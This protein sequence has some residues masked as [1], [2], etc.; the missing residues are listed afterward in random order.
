MRW[1]S[2]AALGLFVVT[3][4]AAP[5]PLGSNRDWSISPVALALGATLL[6]QAIGALRTPDHVMHLGSLAPAATGFVAVTI[7]ALLQNSPLS[8]FAADDKMLAQAYA[9]MGTTFHPQ[10]AIRPDAVIPGIIRWWSYAAAFWLS[11]QFARDLRQAR[12]ILITFIAAACA[13]TLYGL[14]AEA[15]AHFPVN[16]AALFPKIGEGFSGTFVNKNN[17]ATYAGVGMLTALA[18][19]KRYLPSSRERDL[20][21][22]LKA[23][24]LIGSMSGTPALYA[25]AIVLLFAGVMLSISRGG[26]FSLF[27]GLIAA[28]LL[29]RRRSLLVVVIMVIAGLAL[30]GA[31]VGEQIISRFVSMAIYGGDSRGDLYRLTIEGISLRPWTGW[32]LGSFLSVYSL[33]QPLHL[34]HLDFDKAHDTYLELLLDLGI[35]FGVL[36]LAIVPSILVRC[37]IGLRARARDQEIAGLAISSSILVGVHA[38]F[39][40]SLQIPAMGL[41]YAAI[42]GVGWA[43]SWSSREVA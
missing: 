20:P 22:R 39:D 9:T 32:G 12:F 40:F 33:L 2:L 38:L 8:A 4:F 34:G 27:C 7:W 16:G 36:M 29:G 21:F 15:S 19:L 11:A 3:L 37:V 31:T 14:L 24:R 10:I 28:W 25:A 41:T 6:I 17:Y 26:I 30:L 18:M 23:R 43:Q 13:I 1:F 42:L 5:L 35:P